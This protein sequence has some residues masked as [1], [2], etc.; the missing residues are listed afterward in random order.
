MPLAAYD[1]IADWYADY[2]A[3]GAGSAYAQRVT[4]ALARLL[5]PAEPGGGTCLD[6]CCGTGAYVA[7]IRARGWR[8]VGVDL[9]QGQLRRG[10]EVMPVVQADA[11]ALPVRST[12]VPVATC[13]L[14]HSD[15]PDYPAVIHEIGRVLRPGGL[16]VHIG[17]HP[18]F[19]GA[20]ADRSDPARI[21]VDGGYHRTERRFDSFTT[22]GVRNRVGAWHL[23]L[24]GLLNAVVAAGL[25]IVDTV[26]ASPQDAVPDVFAF[27]AV[28]PAH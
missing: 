8:P 2:I 14:G 6:V 26:E 15:V 24:A 4:A 23:P 28:K 7:A 12:S 18:C 16:F 21:I 1:A 10:R 25:R 3:A 5:P 9:S 27:A 17:I 19:T 11:T 20:F 22:Q 13:I